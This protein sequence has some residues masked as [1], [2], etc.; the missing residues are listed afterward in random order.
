MYRFNKKTCCTLV[1]ATAMAAIPALGWAAAPAKD[2]AKPVEIYIN[3]VL[4]PYTLI[5]KITTEVYVLDAS[6]EK[7]A[8]LK[9]F[10]QLQSMAAKHGADG[11]I[12]VKRFIIKDNIATRPAITTSNSMLKDDLDATGEVL[13]ELTLDNYERSIG[14]LSST[15]IDQTFDRS[16]LSEKIIRFSGKAIK[17]N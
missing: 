15:P 12:E 13:D 3:Q 11:L 5:K 14:T 6:S 1:L 16:K 9:A 10:K 2:K 8:E 4:K 17:F 7:D